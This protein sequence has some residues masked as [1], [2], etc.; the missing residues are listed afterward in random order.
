MQIGLS[1]LSE[2]KEKV[3]KVAHK[4]KLERWFLDGQVTGEKG[5]RRSIKG[6]G[7]TDLLVDANR[8]FQLKYRT[9]QKRF[10]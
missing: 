7:H 10:K 8:P 2:G 5:F 3:I 6:K 9:P 1:S 4:N